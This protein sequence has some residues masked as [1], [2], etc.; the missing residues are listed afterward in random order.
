MAFCNSL[1][2]SSSM[3]S[4]SG[5]SGRPLNMNSNTPISFMSILSFCPFY[6]CCGISYQITQWCVQFAFF[7]LYGLCSLFVGLF[8]L[9]ILCCLFIWGF[10]FF[11]PLLTLIFGI[12][13][14]TQL[15]HL[16]RCFQYIWSMFLNECFYFGLFYRISFC[17]YIFCIILSLYSFDLF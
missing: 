10:T 7:G 12:F 8:N 3:P 2:L 6:T 5:G 17:F 11:G 14:C 4:N 1:N 15:T 16:V 9:D 13:A